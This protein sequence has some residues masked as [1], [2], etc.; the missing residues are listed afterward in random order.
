M[1]GTILPLAEATQVTLDE[2]R[3]A[4]ISIKTMLFDA[5]P[6]VRQMIEALYSNGYCFIALNGDAKS[7]QAVADGLNAGQRVNV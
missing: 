6:Q 7:T 2:A 5:T 1:T 4:G 3:K